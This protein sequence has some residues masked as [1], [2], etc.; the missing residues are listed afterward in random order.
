MKAFVS[1]AVLAS[2]VIGMVGGVAAP[3]RAGDTMV[4]FGGGSAPNNDQLS[5]MSNAAYFQRVRK[6]MGVDTIPFELYFADGGKAKVVQAI[7]E[8]SE[9]Q[10]LR[11]L[12]STLFYGSEAAR[13]RYRKAEVPGLVG[14]STVAT[15]EGWFDGAKDKLKG[16][17]RLLF[18]FTGH[19][20]GE[21]GNSSD[22]QRNTTMYM[23]GRQEGYTMRSFETQLDKLDPGVE[24]TLVMVQCH[25][26][27]FA[28]VIYQDGDPAKGFA[29]HLRA[30]FFSTIAPR[31]AAGCTPE[32]DEE[33]YHEFS[34][35][36]FEGLCGESRTGKKIEKP[37]YDRDGKISYDEAFSYTLLTSPTIDIPITTSDQLLRDKS[38]FAKEGDSAEVLP[39]TPEWSKLIAAASPSQKAVLEGLSKEFGFTGEDRLKAAKETADKLQKEIPRRGPG[40]GTPQAEQDAAAARQ[41]QGSTSMP[42]GTQPSTQ[43][44]GRGGMQQGQMGQQQRRNI[45]QARL[46]A[47]LLQRWPELSVPFHPNV[48]EIIEADGKEIMAYLQKQPEWAA[49][50]EGMKQRSAMS[51]KG[52]ANEEKWCKIQRL[53]ERA[54][55]V[56]LANNLS[57][58]AD[59]ESVA[60]YEKLLKLESK[61]L[62]T[63]SMARGN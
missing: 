49:F 26:G 18:Y 28:N 10:K 22:K 13:M 8:E 29:K 53:L 11:N 59:A 45:P 44:A 47:A 62:D 54:K 23:W 1:A 60:T 15:L 31:L 42:A 35:S 2:A 25:S 12:L 50:A 6:V 48:N 3:A 46:Q 61:T 40:P 9:D 57:K 55:T 51:Q 56:V 36:F 38:R 33:D 21:A 14:P 20:G 19:G 16:G 41:A 34:T 4:A 7:A 37:D 17:D 5:L 58:V 52:R 43:A 63:A 24:V 27:G 32:I 30:G 39:E